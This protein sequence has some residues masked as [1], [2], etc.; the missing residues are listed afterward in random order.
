M[1][2]TAISITRWHG[3]GSQRCVGGQRWI[4]ETRHLT[5]GACRLGYVIVFTEC[6]WGFT[7]S[8]AA[9]ADAKHGC[10]VRFIRGYD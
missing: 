9:E 4:N 2:V 6:D 7:E 1:R 8:F 10:R 3:R 5:S